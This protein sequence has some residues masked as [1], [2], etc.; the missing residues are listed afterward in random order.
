[1]EYDPITL[2]GRFYTTNQVNYRQYR[3]LKRLFDLAVCLVLLPVLLV[4]MAFIIVIIKLESPGSPI[5]IQERV[6]KGGS[7]FRIYKFR[8]MLCKRDEQSERAY[9]QAFV[10]NRIIEGSQEM[11]FKAINKKDITRVGKLLRK[12]SLDELPQIFNVLK[13]EMSLIGPR[14]NVPYEVEAYKPWHYERL[15]VL[16]GIT[17][18]AQVLGRSKISFDRIVAYD[19]QYIRRRSLSLDLWIIWKTI[20]VVA[21]GKGAA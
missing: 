21:V 6:G 14:P 5:F 11:G 20:Q 10:A 19:I 4:V 16:P 2:Y 13:G 7:R 17:G 18:M 9:M 12:A 1:M 15:N 8:T 3:L